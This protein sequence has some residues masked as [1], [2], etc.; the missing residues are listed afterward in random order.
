MG[1]GGDKGHGELLPQAGEAAGH[2]GVPGTAGTAWT[3]GQCRSGRMGGNLG[4]GGQSHQSH[5]LPRE[6]DNGQLPRDPTDKSQQHVVLLSTTEQGFE[7]NTLTLF[8][9]VPKEQLFS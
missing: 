1:R 4:T 9:L 5:S 7:K 8:P 3:L 2:P 6:K